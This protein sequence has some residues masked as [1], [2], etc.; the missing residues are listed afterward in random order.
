MDRFPGLAR[1]L[2][3][4]LAQGA[5]HLVNLIQNLALLT[6][7][8]RLAGI[9]LEHSSGD[10]LNRK[11][12]ATQAKM[13]ARLGTVPDVLNRALGKLADEGLISIQRRQIQ[14]LDRAGLE[15]KALQQDSP[16]PKS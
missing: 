5:T 15:R 13:A 12:W 8:A 9:F 16:T 10:T 3:A 4:E 7:E 11:R 14:I 1:I 6:V 2:A